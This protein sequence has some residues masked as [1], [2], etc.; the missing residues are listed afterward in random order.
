MVDVIHECCAGLDVHQATIV[1]CVLGG[2]T[3]PGTP[4]R[5]GK[6]TRTFGTTN[7]EL[8]AL[9]I[10]LK[11]EGVTHA[12]MEA[13]GVYWMPVYAMFEMLGGIDAIVVNARHVKN[14]PG[15]KTDVKDAEWLA[16]MIRHGLVRNSFVPAKPFREL[17]DLTRYRRSLVETQASERQRLIKALETAG[18]KL[19]GVLSDVFGVSGR[20][21]VRAL[22]K[23]TATPREMAGLARGNARKKH[24]ALVKALDVQL[25]AHHRLMLECQLNR[26]ESAEAD[27]ARLDLEIDRRLEPYAEQMAALIAI[28]G[29][30]RIVA[31]TV[32]AEIGTDVSMFL[33]AAHIAAWAGVCPGNH[34]SGGKHK[35]A[36]A[37]KGN[38]HLK[39]ALCNAAISASRKAGSYYKAKYHKLKAKRGGGK[40]ALAIA[41][42]LLI[43]IYHVLSGNTFRDLGETYLDR[44][45]LAKAAARHVRQLQDLGF[46]VNI[47]PISQTAN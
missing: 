38:P 26:V 28:P 19:S 5:P 32:I 1:A 3:K 17:R 9:V 43:A 12:G 30:E 22:I 46:Q 4:A 33:T 13:T 24:A 7:E 23:A 16:D 29:I 11:A 21:I 40:A 27:I 35:P 44:R 8:T 47:Q 14:V 36:S 25:E 6:L 2:K 34:Q 10:W 41:H 15:R 45:N 37:R 42:K 20:A 31:A 39:T 18:I